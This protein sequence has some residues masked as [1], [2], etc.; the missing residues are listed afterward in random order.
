MNEN[1]KNNINELLSKSKYKI[2]NFKSDII[3][4]YNIIFEYCS[5][6]NVLLSNINI[7]I[8][9]I[10]NTNYKLYDLDND[11]NFNL[12][13]TNPYKDGLNLSNLIYKNYSK[14]VV[15]SSYL[16]NKEIIITVD[17]NKLIKIQLLFIYKDNN[18]SIE[19]LNKIC[20]NKIK[21]ENIYNSL[22][23]GT[24]NNNL[25][26]SVVMVYDV[27]Y[28]SNLLELMTLSHKL[29][30]PTYFL[31]YNKNDENLI[32]NYNI[33]IN[34]LTKI[35][36]LNKNSILIKKTDNEIVN[37]RKIIINQ[38]NNELI[39]NLKIILLDSY[40]NNIIFNEKIAINNYNF[41]EILHI[42]INSNYND[43][44]KKIINNNINKDYELNIKYDNIYLINDFRF[45]R[46]NIQIINKKTNNKNVLMYIYNNLDYEVIPTIKKINNNIY[47]PHI[48]VIIRF[49]IINLYYNKLFNK[50]FNTEFEINTIST[51]HKLYN[52]L[53]E[54][55]KIKDDN[56]IIKYLGIFI[57]DKIEKFKLGSVIYR[58]WQYEKN[59]KTLLTTDTIQ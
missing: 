59:N 33:L 13:T 6:T 58:P 26:Q 8:S 15:M 5:K 23:S 35:N 29:Y 31:K 32:N 27:N 34:D 19:L 1:K 55:N 10:Q 25:E 24:I 2:L 45:K 4:L 17:N 21:L 40:A 28:T 44:I 42:L 22:Q 51:I 7:N 52:K 53:L 16:R 54:Y 36:K 14:Y 18:E 47:I 49:L 46:I 12:Y 48:F 57:D 20:Y 9:K 41:N 50:F 30:H 38:L 11:F 43:L 56:K 39:E 3:K 37:L